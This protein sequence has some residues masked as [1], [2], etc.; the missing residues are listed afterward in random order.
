[1]QKE[2]KIKLEQITNIFIIV[3]III[4]TGVIIKKYAFPSVQSKTKIEIGK[5]TSIDDIDWK[6]NGKTLVLALKVDCQ[7]CNASTKALKQIIAEAV[8]NDIKVEVVSSDSRQD[9]ADYLQIHDLSP[10]QNINQIPLNKSGFIGTPSLLFV[11]DQGIVK[12]MWVGRMDDEN[13]AILMGKVKFFI[14]PENFPNEDPAGKQASNQSIIDSQSITPID[15]KAAIE[16]NPNTLIVDVDTRDE[17]KALHISKA[18]NIPGDE[19]QARFARELPKDKTIVFY[20]RCPRDSV[21]KSTKNQLLRL[22]YSNVY[23]L[24]GGLQKWNDSG[25]LT[26]NVQQSVN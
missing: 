12:D 5:T 14:S 2:K 24:E 17:F 21:S 10:V 9:I 3:A 7:F 23:Y 16:K 22:G 25:F 13:I 11:N 20:G 6:Q 26:E 4:V 15:L 18:K 8:N 1:M 19:I